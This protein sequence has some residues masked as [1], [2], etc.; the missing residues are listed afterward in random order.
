MRFIIP[1]VLATV[2]TAQIA[3]AEP[4]P[5]PEEWL[6]ELVEERSPERYEALLELKE[7]NP[8]RYQQALKRIGRMAHR[9]EERPESVKVM[10]EVRELQEEFRE[11]VEEYES[12]SSKKEQKAIRAEMLVLA[13][14][15][16]E[17]KQELRV[18][19]LEQ[20]RARLTELEEEVQVRAE[21]SEQMIEEY[22]DQ[23]L[24]PQP[25]GL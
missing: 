10:E 12:V 13:G 20:A 25:K 16:F 23:A 3:Y 19:R 2:C 1:L 24:E 6:L 18:Q 15:I 14:E 17:I 11:K 21:N 22:V 4:P 7:T 5:P 9:G 8:E